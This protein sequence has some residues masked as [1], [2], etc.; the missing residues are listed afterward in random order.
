MKQRLCCSRTE[1][2]NGFFYNYLLIFVG[3]GCTLVESMPLDRKVVGSNP[4]LVATTWT[5]GL[6]TMDLFTYS[7]LLHVGILT[8]TQCQ[9]LWSRAPLR[10]TGQNGSGQNGTDKMVWTKLYNFMFCVH[11]NSAE[12]NIY[13]VT[14][15]H[16]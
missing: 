10:V 16:K 9:L 4:I 15:S 13:L 5:Y 12:F 8:S 7:C 14:K 11:F 6:W 2:F 1:S 3:R